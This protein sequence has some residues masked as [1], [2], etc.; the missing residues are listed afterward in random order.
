MAI[1][2]SS[3]MIRPPITSDLPSSGGMNLRISGIVVSRWCRT[4][5]SVSRRKVATRAPQL[6]RIVAMRS[7]LRSRP[8]WPSPS[9]ISTA[10]SPVATRCSRSCCATSRAA[11]GAAAAVGR[12]SRDCCASPSTAIAARSSS[13]C[14][15]PRCAVR[16]RAELACAREDFVRDKIARGCFRD[17]LATIRRHRD[18]GHYL[19]LMSASVD[20]YVPEFGRQ[21][22]FDHV[23][24]TD[25]ALGRRS[26]RW[27]ADQRQPAR[28]GKGALRCARC[29]PSAT[30]PKASP[31]ATATPICRTCGSS[32]HG[33]LVNG[34]LAARRAAAELG[35]ACVDWSVTAR[36]ALQA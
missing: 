6:W 14:C 2:T 20:F 10:R 30:M 15:A 9:S 18:A 34:S 21:L 24:S 23:I 11:R 26:A 4:T 33:L 3:N 19:V 1:G 12:D 35:V 17:A 28:R 5:R 13:P 31:T 8:T 32:A 16:T 27:H 25:V 7:G 29:L 22:G 36:L